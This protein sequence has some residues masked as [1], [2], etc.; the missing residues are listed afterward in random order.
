MT[1][2]FLKC[3][4]Q[5]TTNKGRGSLFDEKCQTNLTLTYFKTKHIETLFI[6]IILWFK[7]L[8]IETTKKNVNLVNLFQ[9]QS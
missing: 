6:D 2:F 9:H 7:Y 5:M 3:R 8:D 4:K 1:R